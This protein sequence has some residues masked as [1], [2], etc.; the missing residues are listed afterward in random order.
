MLG[1]QLRKA[2]VCI[3]YFKSEKEHTVKAVGVPSHGVAC[4]THS[5]LDSQ[6]ICLCIIINKRRLRKSCVQCL[7]GLFTVGISVANQ[8]SPFSAGF[9]RIL[10]TVTRLAR[11][12]CSFWEDYIA[13]ARENERCRAERRCMRVSTDREW[14]SKMLY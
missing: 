7:A 10:R 6:L 13:R 12:A 14:N 9:P 5:L 8:H 3:H 1:S 11:S 2:V 4:N